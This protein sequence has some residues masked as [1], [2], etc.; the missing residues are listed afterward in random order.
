MGLIKEIIKYKRDK[1]SYEREVRLAEVR[2]K[3]E[4]PMR[5]EL[6]KYEEN[7][8]LTEAIMAENKKLSDSKDLDKFIQ[9]QNENKRAELIMQ[10]IDKAYANNDDFIQEG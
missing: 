5:L 7:L 10:D 6:K 9:T 8:K 1:I 3:Y 2:W 4:E